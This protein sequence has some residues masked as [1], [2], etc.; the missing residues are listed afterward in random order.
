MDPLSALRQAIVNGKP[1]EVEKDSIIIDGTSYPANIQTAYRSASGAL[2]NLISIWTLYECRTL[3]YQE[4]MAKALR[5]KSQLV[6]VTEKDTLLQYLEGKTDASAHIDRSQLSGAV[7]SGAAALGSTEVVEEKKSDIEV[8]LTNEFDFVTRASVLDAVTTR[9]LRDEIF[10]LFTSPTDK[11]DV[12]SQTPGEKREL[13]TAPQAVPSNRRRVARD[14]MSN[15]RGT[16]YIIV[17][18]GT[19]SLI[20]IYNIKKLLEDNEFVHPDRARE[21]WQGPKPQKITVNRKL[22]DG[23]IQ[24]FRVVD[25]PNAMQR[26]DWIKVVAIFC[27][28]PEWQFR[29]WKWDRVPQPDPITKELVE[30]EDYTPVQIF[31]R[32][33]SIKHHCL[34]SY[35]IPPLFNY[36]IIF[37]FTFLLSY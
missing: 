6:I 27:A 3:P 32:G 7:S 19:G 29:G 4:Y 15:F 26:L 8:I 22:S 34:V 5:E 30:P 16:P 9:N 31:S 10:G 2:L 21:T 28:G 24:E 33:M 11:P 1:V 18:P 13:V 23:T 12:Q 17:P 36:H 25:S 14:V 37:F 20:N 35:C